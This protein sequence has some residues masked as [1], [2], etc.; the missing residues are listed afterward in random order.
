MEKINFM[1]ELNVQTTAT[2]QTSSR[3]MKLVSS[4]E[5]L[6][7]TA[8]FVADAT[9]CV[10]CFSTSCNLCTNCIDV[11]GSRFLNAKVVKEVETMI[12]ELELKVVTATNISKISVHNG[13]S[14]V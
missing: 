2:V 8:Q 13:K 7:Q 12:K 11:R 9:K 6:E 3:L 5:S 1:D 4:A 14:C 10:V